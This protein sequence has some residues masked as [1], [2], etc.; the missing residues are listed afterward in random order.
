M[1]KNSVAQEHSRSEHSLYP[2]EEAK[3]VWV[4]QSLQL[5]CSATS[6]QFIGFFSTQDGRFWKTLGQCS[7][8]WDDN[9]QG[10]KALS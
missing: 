6:Y 5:S 9:R 4:G 10:T 3:T 8:A 2:V 1:H 7:H